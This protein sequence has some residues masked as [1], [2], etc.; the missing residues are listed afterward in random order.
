MN[1][2]DFSL[3]ELTQIAHRFHTTVSK[4]LRETSSAENIDPAAEDAH[5]H[6]GGQRMPCRVVTKSVHHMAT[7]G[8]FAY[9]NAAGELTV[10]IAADVPPMA[11]PKPVASL[12]INE[13][14]FPRVRVAVVDDEAPTTLVRYLN[15]AGFDATHY[16]EAPPVMALLRAE[17]L[18]DAYILDWTLAKGSNSRE[19]IE[20]I[21]QVDAAAPILLLTGTIESNPK[22]ESEIGQMMGKCGVEVFLKP[23]RLLLI[24]K[25]LR[26]MLGQEEAAHS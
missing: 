18:P 3:D 5:I 6:I 16:S 12:Q 10:C 8:L 23:A 7:T 2:G 24:A 15:D 9:T 11:Q 1:Q 21:R 19:L 26:I 13:Q 25:K 4:M 14:S 20:A 22:N 17:Q